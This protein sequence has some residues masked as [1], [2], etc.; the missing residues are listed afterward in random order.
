M[1][2]VLA[3]GLELMG[4]AV[5]AADG[6]TG[7]LHAVFYVANILVIQEHYAEELAGVGSEDRIRFVE[8]YGLVIERGFADG[9]DGGLSGPGAISKFSESR[10]QLAGARRLLMDGCWHRGLRVNPRK[11][12]RAIQD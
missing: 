2:V 7:S 1:H 3:G 4:F 6:E 12:A 9:V 8:D 11:S 5:I 10:D